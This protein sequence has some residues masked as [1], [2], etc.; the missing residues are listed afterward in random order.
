M[1]RGRE[2]QPRSRCVRWRRAE[3]LQ[4]QRAKREGWALVACE[5]PVAGIPCQGLNRG[6]CRWLKGSGKQL[7]HRLRPYYPE[8]ARSRLISEAKQGQ[9]WLVLGWETAWEYRVL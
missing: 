7:E 1:G 3:R 6:R 4:Q 8:R 5:E 2:A 9:A